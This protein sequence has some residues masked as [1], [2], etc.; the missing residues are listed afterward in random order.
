MNEV[1]NKLLLARDKL[2]SEIYLRHSGFIYSASRPFTKS[3]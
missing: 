3:K 2:M 1:V